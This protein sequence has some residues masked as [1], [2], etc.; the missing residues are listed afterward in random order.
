M[1]I[2]AVQNPT[3]KPSM[4]VISNITNANPATVTTTFAHG[5][6]SGTICRLH[7]PPGY[8]IL[9]AN[10]LFGEITVTGDTTFTI[11][12]DTSTFEPYTTPD[13]FPEDKQY[14]QVVPIGENNSIL[15]AAVRNVL[16]YSG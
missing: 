8:G 4:R 15:A 14:P 9:Q 16:P 7:I 6:I 11:D 5:Y 1:A 12:I 10:T 2:L 13:S 3:Y